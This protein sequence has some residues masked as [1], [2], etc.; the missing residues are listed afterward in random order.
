MVGSYQIFLASFAAR[1]PLRYSNENWYNKLYKDYMTSPEANRRTYF[2]QL[3][4]LPMTIDTTDPEE[5]PV[6][7]MAD[8][9][10]IYIHTFLHITNI[11]ALGCRSTSTSNTSIWTPSGPV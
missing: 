6:A 4:Q 3:Y 2:N 5:H 9:I 7:H 8:L 1:L 11:A 10:L